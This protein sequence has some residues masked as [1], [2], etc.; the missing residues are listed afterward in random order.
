MQATPSLLAASARICRRVDGIPLAI[1][2]AAARC[3]QLSPERI[4]TELEN[5]YRLLTGGGRTTLARQRTLQAS[6]DWSHNLLTDDERVAFR[7][8]SVFVGWFPLAAAEGVLAAFGDIDAWTVMDLIARLVDK[9][10][11]VVDD[12]D[13]PAYRML[14]TVRF[15]ALQRARD[16]NELES[17]RDAHAIWWSDWLQERERLH[18]NSGALPLSTSFVPLMDRWYPNLWAAFSWVASDLDRA[19]PFV[20]GLAIYVSTRDRLDDYKVLHSIAVELHRIAHPRWREVVTS[21]A[22]VAVTAGETEFMRGPVTDAYESAVASGDDL[23][24][25]KCLQGLGFLDASGACFIELSQ[26]AQQ[27]DHAELTATGLIGFY[28]LDGAP[29]STI[30][31]QFAHFERLTSSMDHS[32]HILPLHGCTETAI[33]EGRLADAMASSALAF[34][35]TDAAL[36][37]H[38]A[39]QLMGMAQASLGDLLRG[40]AARIS[41][42]LR[43][44]DARILRGVPF[45]WAGIWL[46]SIDIAAHHLSRSPLDGEQVSAALA[47][48]LTDTGTIV[49][50]TLIAELLDRGMVEPV[51][52]AVD[53]F[54][55]IPFADG[56]FRRLVHDWFAAQLA[57]AE[58]N[59]DAA[60]DALRD[61]LPR[62]LDQGAVPIVIDTL[63]L[64]ARLSGPAAVQRAGRLAHAADDSREQIGYHFRFPNHARALEH[65][66]RPSDEAPLSLDHAVAYALRTHGRRGRPTIGWASLTPTELDVARL[67][68]EGATNP[69]IAQKLTMTVNTVKTH[70]A[71][72]FT[73]LDITSRA[74]LAS[75]V[76]QHRND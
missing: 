59:L 21:L 60:D 65:I 34:E 52:S 67:V 43:R 25:A 76:T 41:D 45:Y 33:A 9:S 66:A 14:E 23:S 12:D 38:P 68:A 55:A 13:E 37:T 8:L 10:L 1:E 7:R 26:R 18:F 44:R 15:Y 46:A 63:E 49:V 31:S 50:R 28:F 16:A 71:H 17:L 6:V 51:R 5:H 61:V 72:I 69:V 57:V 3:R 4:A 29:L 19:I 2:L 40:D 42:V 75:I 56:S 22:F 47:S 48:T 39:V 32:V 70:L 20:R 24:A 54:R 36:L 74:Q 58:G 73:K 62:A 11:L 35:L 30:A 64:L 53:R 27:I